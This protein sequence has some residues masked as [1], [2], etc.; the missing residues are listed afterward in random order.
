MGIFLWYNKAMKYIYGPL[1]S[2]R[3]GFSLGVNLTPPKICNLNCIYCQLGKTKIESNERNEYIAIK[4]I[5]AELKC[6]FENNPREAKEINYITFSGSGEPTLNSK[7][8]VLIEMIRNVTDVALAVIT[9]S[10]LLGDPEVRKDIA[11]LDLIVPSLDAVTPEV[12]AKIG[13]PHPDLKI[14]EIIKGLI[15]LRKESRAKIWLE[16]MLVQGVNDDLRQIKKLKTVI[17]QIRPD[18]IQ[19]NSPVRVSAE[20][21]VFPVDKEKLG[22]IKEILGDK[23][24]II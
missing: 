1:H 14:E 21:N 8:G 24:E 19:I 13:R 15:S 2:R 3:L 9:N 11:S 5:F 10:S 16:V 23:C 17:D 20:P 18:K 6:W 4:D 12:F 22:R 7:I